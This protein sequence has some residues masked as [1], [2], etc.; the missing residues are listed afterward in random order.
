MLFEPMYPDV[1]GAITNGARVTID[2][3]QCAIG[4][5]PHQVYIN[6]PCDLI[7]ILQNMVDENM[8][9]KVAIQTPAEDKNGDP[10]VI[11]TPKKMMSLGLRPGEVG[12][13]R[14]PLV[15]YPPTSPG[16][17]FPVRVAVRYRTAKPGKFVRS[18]AG[19]APPSTLSM[20]S[21]KMQ[22]LRRVKYAAQTWHESTD[23]ITT[24]FDVAP[25]RI[26]T[27]PQNLEPRYETLWTNDSMLVERQ[28]VRGKVET[29]RRVAAGITRSSVYEPLI[30]AVDER[31]G[32]RG[33]PLHPGEARAIAKIMTYTLDQGMELEPGFREEES[34]W[35]RT[36]CQVLAHNDEVEDWTRGEL[37]VKYLFDAAL[38]DAIQ[39]GF[40][41]IQPKVR[42]DLG[43]EQERI[44]YANRVLTWLVGKGEVDL[45][46][47][48]L[49]LVMAGII[50]NQIVSGRYDNPWELLDQVMEAL[51]G[52]RRLFTGESY[53]IF[54]MT[55][56]L[57]EEAAV[58]LK[59][60]RIPR[61]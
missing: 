49:P 3:L 2:A 38:F 12:V 61:Y 54:E 31:F 7:V 32:K 11:E 17:N 42:E 10:V 14:M 59:A 21:F 52:R 6:Q 30:E 33:L 26:P 58:G 15:A 46:Y 40:S 5:S 8:Q 28:L 53:I 1:L 37:V 16:K 24:Y 57:L 27:I 43:D 22:D 29:A 13:L 39:L 34:L 25:K 60:A 47:L 9:V 4:V 19:G 23:I 51:N 41:V 18:L 35:F 50:V 56:N 45:S 55:Q 20:S 36:L 48:Y 44:N